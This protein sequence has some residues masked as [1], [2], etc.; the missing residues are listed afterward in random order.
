[1]AGQAGTNVAKRLLVSTTLKA[2]RRRSKE[3]LLRYF[4]IASFTN[5][6]SKQTSFNIPI[7]RSMK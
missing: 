1:M 5:P 6:S 3:R 2:N 4:K 7:S